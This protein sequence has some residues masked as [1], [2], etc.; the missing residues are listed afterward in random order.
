MK[1]NSDHFGV[2][3][4]GKDDLQSRSR[5]ADVRKAMFHNAYYLTWGT[6]GEPPLPTYEVTLNRVLRGVLP[7]AFPWLFKQAARRAVSSKAALRWGSDGLGFRR[8]LHP[9][10]VCLFGKWIIDTENP[11]SGHFHEGTE[12]LIVGRYSTCCT[13]TRRGFTRSLSLVG[14]IYPTTDTE[15]SEPL[16]TADFITQQDLGGER[17]EYI[18]DAILLNAP[19]VTPWRRGW[20]LPI[21]LISGLVFRVV[22]REPAIRQLH[23]VAELGKAESEPTRAPQ[24]MR[25]SVVPEQVRI[26]GEQLDFRDEVLAQIYDRGSDEATGRKLTFN[27]EVTDEGNRRGVLVQRRTFQNWRKIGRIEFTEGVASYNADFVLHF[28]H[29]RWRANTNDAATATEIR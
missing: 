4:F 1:I 8:L 16:E 21:L 9:N 29:P 10:G 5:Y 17:S 3:D 2:Q 14:K 25:L 23:T 18:N 13:E 12:A 15:H 6:V 19:N 20:G 22:N 26:H 24:F 27:I 28:N 7:F 11:Y